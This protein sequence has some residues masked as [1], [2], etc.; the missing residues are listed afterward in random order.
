MSTKPAPEP[1]PNP[2][3][4][5][6][7]KKDELPE[8]ELEKVAGGTVSNIMKSQQDTATNAIRNIRG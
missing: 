1:K 2:E 4:E 7:E 3:A 6:E 8:A 5:S